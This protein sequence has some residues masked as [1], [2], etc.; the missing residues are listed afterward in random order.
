MRPCIALLLASIPLASWACDTGRVPGGAA[1]L[2]QDASE[3]T[4][5]ASLWPDAQPSFDGT[6]GDASPPISELDAAPSPDVP[7]AQADAALDSGIQDAVASDAAAP[8]AALVD[9]TAH[10]SAIADATAHDSA[11]ADAQGIDATVSS[12]SGAEPGSVCGSCMSDSDCPA[13]T[14][15]NTNFATMRRTC[16]EP[17]SMTPG[18]GCVLRPAAC[19]LTWCSC[20]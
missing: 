20:L 18:Q 4:E 14:S 7:T 11:T 5:D 3:A 17:C 2:R 9:A 1:R 6:F 10:D 15:C 12:D 13:G 19:L 16:Q 8:D